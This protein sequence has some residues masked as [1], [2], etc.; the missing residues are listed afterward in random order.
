MHFCLGL[1]LAI[2]Q[3]KLREI[4]KKIDQLLDVGRKSAKTKLTEALTSLEHEN[5]AD[6]YEAFNKA[7]DKVNFRFHRSNLHIFFI[8]L[9]CPSLYLLSVVGVR[10][11]VPLKIPAVVLL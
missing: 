3:R 8:L 11:P 10:C 5:Y 7:A 9:I 1:T 6:A 2:I 4:S